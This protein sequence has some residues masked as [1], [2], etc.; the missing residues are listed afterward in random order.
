[1][2]LNVYLRDY[3]SSSFTALTCQK[4]KRFCLNF[5][6]NLSLQDPLCQDKHLRS[7]ARIIVPGPVLSST[8][9]LWH[10]VNSA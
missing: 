3:V 8:V 6:A 7:C 2:W 4:K 1:M 9:M 10:P 5:N